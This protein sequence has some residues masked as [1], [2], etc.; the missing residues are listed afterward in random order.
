M[1]EFPPSLCLLLAVIESHSLLSH[2]AKIE[3]LIGVWKRIEITDSRRRT[4]KEKVTN[5][6][7][8]VV[9]GDE[10]AVGAATRDADSKELGTVAGAVIHVVIRKAEV[11]P[12]W[13]WEGRYYEIVTYAEDNWNDLLRLL[14]E[15]TPEIDVHA[16]AINI[17]VDNHVVWEVPR[18]SSIIRESC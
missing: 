11:P 16:V 18:T 1:P 3:E 13:R 9:L 14:C 4:V 10:A 2:F 5:V 12:D 15:F 7:K 6:I 17:D 8:A